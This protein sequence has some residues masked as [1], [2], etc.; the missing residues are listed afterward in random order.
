M[1]VFR[2]QYMRMLRGLEEFV[3]LV[4]RLESLLV[5]NH[6]QL[7]VMTPCPGL[8]FHES[9]SVYQLFCGVRCH[10]GDDLTT[11]RAYSSIDLMG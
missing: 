8:L 11:C 2:G 7:T 4:T 1:I 6:V 5:A 3:A 9:S 10:Y